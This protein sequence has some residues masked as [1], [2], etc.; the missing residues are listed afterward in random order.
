MYQKL[1][2]IVLIC[3]LTFLG[4]C[5]GYHPQ[6]AEPKGQADKSVWLFYYREQFRG[7]G[8]SALPPKDDAPDVARQAYM[9]AHKEW[10]DQRAKI[11]LGAM[12]GGVAIGAAIAVKASDGR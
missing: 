7:Y 3:G 1:I 12:L 4:A 11:L 5:T 6:V 9:E 2:S 8:D 10:K